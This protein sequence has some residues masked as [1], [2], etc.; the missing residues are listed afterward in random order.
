MC[1]NTSNIYK[2]STRHEAVLEGPGSKLG[3][4]TAGLTDRRECVQTVVEAIESGY[5]HVDTA[6]WYYNEE[7]VGEAIEQSTVDRE[8]LFVATKL[9]QENLGYEDVIETTEESLERLGLDIIDLIYV[10]WPTD[11]YEPAETLPAL[12]E[13]VDRGLVDRL[14]V[15]NFTRELLEEARDRLDQSIAAHQIEYHPLFHQDSLVEYCEANDIHVVG[16]S[17][18][19]K[20]EVLSD[21]V[22]EDIATEYDATAA[23]VCLAWAMEKGVVPIPKARGDHVRENVAARKLEL[24][25]EMVARIDAIERTERTADPE[26]APW[27]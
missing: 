6:Q 3:F 9:Y 12:D 21:P 11:A 27:N 24:T 19:A 8:S 26:W 20:G 22:V 5:Q 16:F 2:S 14:G 13:L 23:Q 15:S 10:H 18:L 4:G 25:P 1:L 17:P 7:Y